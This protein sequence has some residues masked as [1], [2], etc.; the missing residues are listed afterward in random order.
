MQSNN[1]NKE[2]LPAGWKLVKESSNSSYI[3]KEFLFKDF[4]Q[5]WS[6]MS[7]VALKAEQMGHHPDWS[8]VYNRV[9]IK[10]TTHDLGNQVG[11]NDYALANICESL[12]L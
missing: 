11:P 10:L 1:N 8:N 5:A 3:Q 9:S 6:F 12:S 4:V 2:V 7:A